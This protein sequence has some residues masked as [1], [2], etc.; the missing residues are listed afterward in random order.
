MRG[1]GGW[2]ESRACGR[3]GED[4][5]D[6]E[7]EEE[8][9]DDDDE[10]RCSGVGEGEDE[11]NDD[12]K[13]NDD[14]DEDED[15]D[16]EDAEEDK[17]EEEAEDEG[18]EDDVG[19]EGGVSKGEVCGVGCACVEMRKW[20]VEPCPSTLSAQIRPPIFSTRLLQMERPRPN[21]T[22]NTQT[23]NSKHQ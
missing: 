23:H 10:G 2:R 8:K 11:D 15:D 19:V 12:E 13:D 7:D 17:I 6:T 14:E 5:D 1:E 16:N 22:H 3:D 21:G 20:K 4:D 18:E 9:D